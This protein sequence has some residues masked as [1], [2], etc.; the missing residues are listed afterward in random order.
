MTETSEKFRP[1]YGKSFRCIGSACE[2]TCCHGWSIPVDKATYEKYQGFPEGDLSTRTAQY[3]SI[4][5]GNP[6]DSLYAQINLTA[7]KD[8]PFLTDER[9]C[10]I[11]SRHG[12][13][14]LSATCSIYPRVLNQAEGEI[15]VSLYLSCP[16]AARMVLLNPQFAEI[17]SEDNPYFRTDQFSRLA[18][19]GDGSIH[20]PYGYFYEVRDC[21]VT[22]LRDRNRP[23]WQRIFLLGTLCQRLDGFK[24]VAQDQE[25]PQ[26]LADYRNIVSTGAL[27]N[28]MDSIPAQPATQLDTVLRLADMRMREGAAGER[29]RDCFQDF[30]KGVG[31]APN[32]TAADYAPHYLE[33]EARYSGPFFAAHPFILENYLLNYVF[34]TLFP[35]G[36]EASAHHTPQSIFDEFVLMATQYAV[37]RGLLIG[38]A[39]HYRERF[40]AEHVIKLVQSFSKA[41]EHSPSY[42]KKA[43]DFIREHK[44]DGNQ[45]LATLLKV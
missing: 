30:V 42:L 5:K 27:R 3:V 37:I 43:G 14:Y 10:D 41:V 4:N 12:A 16:E 17:D 11:Q 39:G 44:L 45:G 36:R 20:K 28:E 40:G 26:V 1:R 33:A 19:N 9:L 31:Y 7:T 38:M 32:L 29:F 25:V 18:G 15:E 6:S 34:R 24:T 21:I 2:D 8:C 23:L 13:E 35:F 22:L